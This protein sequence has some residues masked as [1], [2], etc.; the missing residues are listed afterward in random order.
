MKEEEEDKGFLNGNRTVKNNSNPSIYKG[1][2]KKVNEKRKKNR[3]RKTYGSRTPPCSKTF[4][5]MEICPQTCINTGFLNTV[6]TFVHNHFTLKECMQI[7][8]LQEDLIKK[9]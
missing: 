6:P 8:K 2:R 3:K 4:Q 9:G 5:F 7:Q 1:L